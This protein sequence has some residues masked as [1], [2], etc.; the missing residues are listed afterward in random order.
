MRK[1]QFE[2]GNIKPRVPLLEEVLN[3]ELGVS[4]DVLKATKQLIGGIK[5]IVKASNLEFSNTNM[6]TQ[7][8][9]GKLNLGEK[10]VVR[11][12]VTIVY[13]A[14][15]K[16]YKENC[17]IFNDVS[18]DNWTNTIHVCIDVVNKV[19]DVAGTEGLIQHELTHAYQTL[20]RLDK[21]Y[22]IEVSDSYYAAAEHWQGKNDENLSAASLVVYFMNEGELSANANELYPLFLKSF[23]NNGTDY[24]PVLAETFFYKS[25]LKVRDLNKRIETQG[26]DILT[27]S[28]K[29]LNVPV[30]KL[31][32]M[33]S[34]FPKRAMAFISKVLAKAK[35]DYD[36]EMSKHSLDYG[37]NK[38]KRRL[39]EKIK[40]FDENLTS[41]LDLSEILSEVLSSMSDE[42]FNEAWNKVKNK[43]GYNGTGN[44]IL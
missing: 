40:Y 13:Y 33:C 10:Y 34:V 41:E 8:C 24:Y 17:N 5:E 7:D 18:Y 6:Y 43:V 36:A 29:I 20:L 38:Q 31:A 11:F 4:E 2:F 16:V 44:Q 35:K 30:G 1:M 14:N 9:E 19:F 32:N 25:I 26:R 22:E 37:I 12:E 27:K 21:E 23:Q 39:Q 42:E 3:E 15:K 28:S